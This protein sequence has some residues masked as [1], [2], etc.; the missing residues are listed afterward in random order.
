LK[1]VVGGLALNTTV[2]INSLSN[3]PPPFFNLWRTRKLPSVVPTS[4]VSVKRGREVA[5][6][7]SEVAAIH[8]QPV[9]EHVSDQQS[10]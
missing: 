8:C 9:S 2:K 1:T 7:V 3:A 5:V 6:E 10:D 4:A